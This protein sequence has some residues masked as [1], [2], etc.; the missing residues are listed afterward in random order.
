MVSIK[1]AEMRA[2][3]KMLYN[4]L[5]PIKVFKGPE[6]NTKLHYICP[7]VKENVVKCLM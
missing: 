2:C 5:V 3:F 1:R 6:N 4:I 7:A